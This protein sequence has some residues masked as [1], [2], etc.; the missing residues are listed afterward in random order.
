MGLLSLDWASPPKSHWKETQIN[1]RDTKTAHVTTKKDKMIAKWQ[2]RDTETPTA[3]LQRDTKWPQSDTKW[4]QTLP[5]NQITKRQMELQ[6]DHKT[7]KKHKTSYKVSVY[8]YQTENPCNFNRFK[9]NPLTLTTNT[10][11]FNAWIRFRLQ[12]QAALKNV[13]FL[14]TSISIYS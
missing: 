1:P 7:T 13:I 2:Q 5:V 3:P 10:W 6:H 11:H 12:F 14:H 4:W 9:S 8:P